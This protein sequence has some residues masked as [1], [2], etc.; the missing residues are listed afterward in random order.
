[1]SNLRFGGSPLLFITFYSN[2]LGRGVAGKAACY[3]GSISS[4]CQSV[5]YLPRVACCMKLVD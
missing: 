4:S 1:M 2:L 5:V 3:A